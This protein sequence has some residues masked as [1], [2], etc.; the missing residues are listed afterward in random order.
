VFPVILTEIV[1]VSVSIED[2][3]K[4][5]DVASTIKFVPEIV[6]DKS[7]F[8]ESEYYNAQVP[9]LQPSVIDPLSSVSWP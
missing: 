5:T 9:T 2:K 3:V 4:V 7:V 8:A 1:L 6:S